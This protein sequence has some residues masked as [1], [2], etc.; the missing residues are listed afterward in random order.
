[1]NQ[2]HGVK[3]NHLTAID[4]RDGGDHDVG[5]G[6]VRGVLE[7]HANGQEVGAVD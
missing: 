4:R 1:M 2:R 7:P 5:D 3:D 6:R